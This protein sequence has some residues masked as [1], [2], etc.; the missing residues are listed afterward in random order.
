M[1]TFWWDFVRGRATITKDKA[2]SLTLVSFGV[3]TLA[4]HI[5]MPKHAWFEVCRFSSQGVTQLISC[6]TKP[7]AVQSW[8]LCRISAFSIGVLTCNLGEFT[9]IRDL[10]KI[11]ISVCYEISWVWLIPL[12][13]PLFALLIAPASFTCLGQGG[14]LG[15]AGAAKFQG[16]GLVTNQGSNKQKCGSLEHCSRCVCGCVVGVGVVVCLCFCK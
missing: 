9:F 1:R 13:I 6:E 2:K 15:T 5:H 7:P 14:F 4:R 3:P 11:T 16:G 12:I 10:I 8:T